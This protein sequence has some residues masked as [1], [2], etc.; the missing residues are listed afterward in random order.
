MN[1]PD[2]ADVFALEMHPDKKE[3]YLVDGI[4]HT[5]EKLKAKLHVKFLGLNIPIKKTFYK[6]IYGSTLKNKTGFYSVRTPSTTNINAIEQWWRMNKANSFT[7][8]YTALEMKALSGYNIGYADKNDT[9]FYIV[10][11]FC[12]Q[13]FVRSN[14]LVRVQFL[15]QSDFKIYFKRSCPFRT[16]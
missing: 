10:L 15:M 13:L 12:I 14:S 5:L 4:E 7:E 2:K 1:Y 6:S 11:Y 16:L 9:I 3:V 8:F